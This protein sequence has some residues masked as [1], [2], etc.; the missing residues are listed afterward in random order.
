MTI[1]R[2]RGGWHPGWALPRTGTPHGWHRTILEGC[3]M[4]SIVYIVGAVVIIIVVLKVLGL[5]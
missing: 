4:N 2:V 5:Y 1:P 3:H